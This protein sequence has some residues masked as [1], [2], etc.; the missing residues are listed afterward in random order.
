M[1]D[2][3]ISHCYLTYDEVLIKAQTIQPHFAAD[4][5][6]FATYN[7]W[8]TSTVNTQ[9][10]SGI[11]FSQKDF[12]ENS[13]MAE[14]KGLTNVLDVKLAD[15][16]HCYEKLNYYVNKGLENSAVSHEPFGYAGFQKAR[17]SVKRMIPLLNQAIAAISYEGNEP[18]LLAAGMLHDLAIEMTNI[19]AELTATHEELK[20]LKKQHLIV[21]RERIN[22]FNSMWDTLSKICE[23]AKI[24]FVN[25]TPH[26]AIYELFDIEDM[27]VDHDEPIEMK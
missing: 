3:P 1:E 14:I 23:D 5:N 24:I 18:K 11:Y 7:P 9:L 19:A 12:S 10:L 4:L 15:A 17:C 13:L 25:D 6:R 21:T 22:L 26:L 27:D 20:I 2:L 8:F 16:R